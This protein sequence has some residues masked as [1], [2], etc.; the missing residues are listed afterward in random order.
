[1]AK[2]LSRLK[3]SLLETTQDM[4]ASGLMDEETY[5]QIITRHVDPEQ[6]PMTNPL[7]PEAIRS[8]RECAN[9]S[10]AV[11]AQRLNL[12][13]GYISQ[14]ERGVKRPTGATLVLLNAIQRKGIEVVLW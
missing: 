7:T 12:T 3:Q 11:F 13:P 2:K 1:M 6:R 8:L 9:M 10:Q 14:L 4:Y 5:N